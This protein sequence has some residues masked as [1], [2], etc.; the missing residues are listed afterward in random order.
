MLQTTGCENYF[1]L[2]DITRNVNHEGAHYY[3]DYNDYHDIYYWTSKNTS[4]D[5]K[6]SNWY[7][8]QSEAGVVMPEYPIDSFHCGTKSTGW[9]NGTHPQEINHTK[10]ITVCFHIWTN[11]CW[12][13]VNIL[14]T[15]CGDYYVYYLPETH[16]FWESRYCGAA[17]ATKPLK[18]CASTPAINVGYVHKNNLSSIAIFNT[19]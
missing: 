18:P 2:D 9:L 5:W 6:G 15:N 1:I 4:V 12:D 7:R 8:F 17:Q 19:I 10:N 16:F 13:K 14:V 11:Y 3:E